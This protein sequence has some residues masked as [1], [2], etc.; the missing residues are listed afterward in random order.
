METNCK[1]TLQ[2]RTAFFQMRVFN[3]E[4]HVQIS[5][6]Y[7][8]EHV[9][10]RVE[11]ERGSRECEVFCTKRGW[12]WSKIIPLVEFLNDLFAWEKH[13]ITKRAV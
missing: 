13:I 8:R 11:R 5:L 4:V 9:K 1:A 6:L 2:M 3:D 12:H 7:G 10:I